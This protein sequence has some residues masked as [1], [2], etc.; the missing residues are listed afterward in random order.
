MQSQIFALGLDY[1]I[2]GVLKYTKSIQCLKRIFNSY[3][4]SLA[5]KLI[6][7]LKFC[8]THEILKVGLQK[9]VH[10]GH[11]GQGNLLI[12]EEALL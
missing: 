4:E 11:V 3:A 1:S 12:Q 6:V 9:L 8:L 2:Q 10:T 5:R 7:V